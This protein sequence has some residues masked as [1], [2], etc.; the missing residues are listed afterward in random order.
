MR[1]GIKE[2]TI[3]YY[4]NAEQAIAWLE[5]EGYEILFIKEIF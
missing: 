5:L 4:V 3:R 2:K 1:D